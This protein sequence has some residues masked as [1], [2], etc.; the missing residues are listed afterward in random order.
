M[1]DVSVLYEGN[2]EEAARYA[3]QAARTHYNAHAQV[4]LS[5]AEVSRL[6]ADRQLSL[7]AA[8]PSPSPN[9]Y[10]AREPS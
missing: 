2:D 4:Q 9:G 10:G 5:A 8:K 7:A 1:A 6:D 3:A